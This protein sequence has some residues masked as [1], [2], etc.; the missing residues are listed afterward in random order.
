MWNHCWF[1]AVFGEAW[2]SLSF[3]SSVVGPSLFCGLG[4]YQAIQLAVLGNLQ[5]VVFSEPK[6]GEELNSRGQSI[7]LLPLTLR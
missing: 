1:G 3:E 6:G 4:W 5:W 2:K 7:S